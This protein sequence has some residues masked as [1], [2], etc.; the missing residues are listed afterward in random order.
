[1]V[2]AKE[3]NVALCGRGTGSWGTDVSNEEFRK[4]AEGDGIDYPKDGTLCCVWRRSPCR[5]A[6]VHSYDGECAQKM[7]GL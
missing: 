2:G 6:S 1:M 5:N 3:R 4:P 7:E